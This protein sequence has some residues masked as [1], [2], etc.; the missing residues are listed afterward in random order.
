LRGW[1]KTRE[2]EQTIYKIEVI[3]SKS[4]AKL[5]EQDRTSVTEY[6]PI[7]L[8]EKLKGKDK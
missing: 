1:S 8:T 4:L 2:D 7:K 6:H 3:F 5:D